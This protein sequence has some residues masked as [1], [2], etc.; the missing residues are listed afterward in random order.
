MADEPRACPGCGG[1]MTPHSIRSLRLDLCPSCGGVWFDAGEFGRVS[2]LGSRAVDT[3]VAEEPPD[4]RP[5]PTKL[6][7]HCPIDGECLNPYHFAGSG[8]VMLCG[9]P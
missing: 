5:A 9:C 1:G 6:V 3:I 2:R 8:D 4:V 7:H